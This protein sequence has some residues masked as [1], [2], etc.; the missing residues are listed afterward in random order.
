MQ[1][2]VNSS[3]VQNG[4][5]VWI[6]FYT[7]CWYVLFT[8][9]LSL[10]GPVYSAYFTTTRIILVFSFMLSVMLISWIFTSLAEKRLNEHYL[11]VKSIKE[12]TILRFVQIAILFS[13][14]IKLILLI[15]F[16]QSQ[17]LPDVKQGSIF[18]SL[19]SSYTAKKRAEF[20]ADIFRQIDSLAKFIYYFALCSG[21]FWFGKLRVYYRVPFLLMLVSDFA[22]NWL[23][24]GTMR[25]ISTTFLALGLM[26]VVL[27]YRK[28]GKLPKKAIIVFFLLGL[29]G[30]IAL[31]NVFNAR[32]TLWKWDP[33]RLDLN[34]YMSI[35]RQSVLTRIVPPN[36]RMPFAM[37][38]SYLSQGY[39]GLG[40]C[41]TTPFEWT[42]GLGAVRGINSI[43][44]QV[45]PFVPIVLNRTYPLRAEEIYGYDGLSVW[46][47]MFPWLAGDLTFAGSLIYMGVSAYILAICWAE[48]VDE[49]NP[50]SFTMLFLLTI[51]YAFMTANNQ[52]FINRGESFAALVILFSWGIMHK[53]TNFRH[54]R[55]TI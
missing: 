1:P 26:V 44:N 38:V 45:F 46:H 4:V 30:T 37:V 53:R 6:P 51:Q 11:H 39:F 55:N 52:L 13:A 8:L 20:E 43:V 24:I 9:S 10:M 14:V 17:G 32:A 3:G 36:L 23:F 54:L 7:L 35:N 25:G 50:I 5:S 40:V 27:T 19:A 22:Y 12:G 34:A 41:L 49:D 48:S 47:T 29:L 16:L 18:S 28:Y 2:S 33:N 21:L 15:H 31:M 42:F